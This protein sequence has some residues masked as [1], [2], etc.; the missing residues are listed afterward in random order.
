MTEHKRVRKEF[1]GGKVQIS[2]HYKGG[3]LYL[4]MVHIG[5]LSLIYGG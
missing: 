4:L 3:K 2:L 1:F 5:N